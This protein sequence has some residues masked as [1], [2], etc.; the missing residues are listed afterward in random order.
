MIVPEAVISAI[1]YIALAAFFGQLVAAGFLLPQGQPATLRRALL[2]WATGSLI[3]FLFVSVAALIL[4]GSKLQRGFPSSDLLWRY[5]TLTQSGQVWLAREIYGALLALLIVLLAR[6]DATGNVL[7]AA[8]LFALPLVVSRSLTSHA[9]AVREDTALA[10]S[11]D[12]I[13]LLATAL[14]GGGLFGLWHSLRFARAERGENPSLA[15][16][17]VK[18]FSCLA[19]VSVPLLIITGLYQSW[20]H[21]GSFPTLFGTDYGKVLLLKLTLLLMMLSIGALN[22]L[23][24]KPLLARADK[25]TSQATAQK[26]LRRIGLESVLGL[27]IFGVTGLLTVLPPGVHAVHQISAAPETASPRPLQPA[28]GARVKILSP[29]PDQVFAGDRVPLKFSLIKGKRGHHVHAYVDGELMG[30]FESKQ[31]TL[32]GIASGRHILELRVV[33]ADHQTELDAQDRIE[34]I[35]K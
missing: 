18:R 32:N 5:L 31:G 34:F 6:K 26:A 24:T 2:V 21:V 27:A 35:V 29:A 16:A 30:M 17:I 28:E 33:A 8:A 19:L 23:S 14:W 4:Q 22:F 3:L 20:I 7:R 13:H 10:V 1:S 25:N 11:S 15:T 9:I 12:A